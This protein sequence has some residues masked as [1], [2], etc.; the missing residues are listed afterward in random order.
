M[1]AHLRTFLLTTIE[2]LPHKQP[3]QS[4]TNHD[5]K[6][7]RLHFTSNMGNEEDL[8]ANL[9]DPEL[10]P[11]DSSEFTK[12]EQQPVRCNDAWA[13]VL[14]YGNVIAIAAVAGSL[15]VPAISSYNKS[16]D[17][18][19]GKEVVD[20]GNSNIDY[21]GIIYGAC[22]D[23]AEKPMRWPV[24]GYEIRDRPNLF[25]NSFLLPPCFVLN[26]QPGSLQPRWSLERRPSSF[27]RSVFSSCPGRCE[28]SWSSR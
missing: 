18:S 6:I 19:F 27:R 22:W 24:L 11:V 2:G 17:H 10:P 4:I 16:N 8:T 28:I 23:A 15:G 14:F 7:G 20:G 9:I 21:E 13:A 3:H 5:T 12:G 1:S 25:A 26:V